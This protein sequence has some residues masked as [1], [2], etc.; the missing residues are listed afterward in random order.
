MGSKALVGFHASYLVKN[1]AAAESGSGDA[2]F[3]AYLFGDRH[4]RKHDRVLY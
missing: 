3:R 2:V 1:G 4:S